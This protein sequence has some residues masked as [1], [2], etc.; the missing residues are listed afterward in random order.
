MKTLIEHIKV[1]NKIIGDCV[2]YHRTKLK[3]TQEVFAEKCELSTDTIS[4]LERGQ[5][6]PSL[7]TLKRI[8]NHINLPIKDMLINNGVYE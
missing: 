7:L 8:S 3:E 2:L 4:L 6:N 1:E 5:L